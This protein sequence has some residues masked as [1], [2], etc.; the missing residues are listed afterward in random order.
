MPVTKLVFSGTTYYVIGT[1]H[2][3]HHSVEEVRT[4]IAELA[5]EVV[6]VELD[7]ARYDALTGRIGIAR[8]HDEQMR[9]LLIG[10]SVY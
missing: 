6:C 7:R 4:A 9:E 5:P 1:A 8:A 2:V 10:I 3:S